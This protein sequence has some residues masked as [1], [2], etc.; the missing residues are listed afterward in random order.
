[1]LRIGAEL[2][3]ATVFS[4]IVQTIIIKPGGV[5]F[6]NLHLI[7]AVGIAFG[8]TKDKRGEAAFAGLIAGLIIT[9]LVPLLVKE[10]FMVQSI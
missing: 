8:F 4:K 9:T 10:F 7:F 6:D 3:D 1:M 5:V 2:P